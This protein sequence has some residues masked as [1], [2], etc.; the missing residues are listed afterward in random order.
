MWYFGFILALVLLR[1]GST[2]RD[3]NALTIVLVASLVSLALVTFVTHSI[4]AHWKLVIPGA[5]ETLTIWALAALGKDRSSFFQ[6]IMLLVAWGDHLQCYLDLIWNT[7]VV[8][9]NYSKILEAVAVGQLLG[10]YD[11]AFSMCRACQRWF[12]VWAVGSRFVP[13]S[14]GSSAMVRTP[15]HAAQ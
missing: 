13:A 14:S 9:D 7:N 1:L 15:D 11:T 10:F 6:A 3:R 12:H 2:K 4:T 8:Y 5:V